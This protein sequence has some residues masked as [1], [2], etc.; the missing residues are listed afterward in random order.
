MNITESIFSEI[1]LTST[2]WEYVENS[3]KS[4]SERDLFFRTAAA[5]KLF[6]TG[7][8]TL[9]QKFNADKNNNR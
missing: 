7:R 9:Y 4:Y 6:R 5:T 2:W 8:K 1:I 3:N